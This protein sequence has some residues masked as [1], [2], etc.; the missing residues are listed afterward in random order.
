L[1]PNEKRPRERREEEEFRIRANLILDEWM[2]Y[3]MKT[4]HPRPSL[5]NLCAEDVNSQGPDKGI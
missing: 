1:H 5:L 3:L 2:I 4:T